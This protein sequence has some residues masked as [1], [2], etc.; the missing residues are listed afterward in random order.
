MGLWADTSSGGLSVRP[1]SGKIEGRFL[2]V[3]F[4]IWGLIGLAINLFYVISMPSQVGVG[5]I[6]GEL[7]WIGGMLLFGLAAFFELAW[8][9]R[10]A[11][12]A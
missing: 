4:W 1:P 10:R 5:M 3:I 11:D 7:L 12:Q 9:H 6:A 2:M 8:A